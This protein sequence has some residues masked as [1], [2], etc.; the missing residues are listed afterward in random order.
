MTRPGRWWIEA[1]GGRD[2]GKGRSTR[3]RTPD[4][5]RGEI[6]P[7]VSENLNEAIAVAGPERSSRDNG[8][9]N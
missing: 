6:L 1:A 4:P 5:A 7:G 2:D 8:G 3:V 9:D